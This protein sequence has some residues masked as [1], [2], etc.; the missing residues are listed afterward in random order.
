MIQKI[1]PLRIK[2][3]D[4]LER[5]RS[6]SNEHDYDYSQLGMSRFNDSHRFI[7][8]TVKQTIEE[9]ECPQIIHKSVNDTK[10][11]LSQY[12]DLLNSQ[13]FYSGRRQ[14]FFK[15]AAEEQPDP[16][17]HLKLSNLKSSLDRNSKSS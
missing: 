9:P 6:C 7:P 10:V 13:G 17:Y 5:N 3:Q 11:D 4:I 16:Y 14:P 8:T 2:P 12:V 1:S 15:P